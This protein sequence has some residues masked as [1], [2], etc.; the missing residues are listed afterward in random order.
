MKKILF[1]IIALFSVC[2]LSGCGKNDNIKILKCSGVNKGN[3][4]NAYGEVKYTF[5]DDKLSKAELTATFKD[6]T[7]DDLSSQWD[8]IKTQFTEQNEPVEEVGYKRLVRSDDKNYT[9][10]VLLEI[11]FEKIS[12]ETMEKYEVSY[13]KDITYEEVKKDTEEEGTFVCE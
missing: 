10:T 13:S 3:N 4:M 12:K 6:I 1:L 5:K 2:I 11:D 7:I 8:S 9:F